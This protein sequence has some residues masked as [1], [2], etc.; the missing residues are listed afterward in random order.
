MTSPHFD[1]KSELNQQRI[2]QIAAF[3]FK[4]GDKANPLGMSKETRRKIAENAQ[5]ATELRQELLMS[6]HDSLREHREA[7]AHAQQ[8]LG[9]LIMT[10]M[11]IE[12]AGDVKALNEHDFKI[13]K[14]QSFLA[15]QDLAITSIRADVLKLMKDAEDRGFGTPIATTDLKSSDGSMSQRPTTIEFVSP[16]VAPGGEEAEE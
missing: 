5:L 12:E 8:D 14:H 13:H 7:R 2:R 3:R 15:S 4:K 1:P 10:R 6:L 11:D 9:A 16:E